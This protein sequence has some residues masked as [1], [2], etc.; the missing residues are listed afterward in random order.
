MYLLNNIEEYELL[1]EIF[2]SAGDIIFLLSTEGDILNINIEAVNSYGYTEEELLS[3]NIFQ[4]INE[5]KADGG[6]EQFK[7]AKDKP[8]IFESKHFRKDGSSFNVEVKSTD[9]R[10]KNEKYVLYII[11]DITERLKIEKENLKWAYKFEKSQESI[12]SKTLDE[13]S[14]ETIST[15]LE[16][17]A[18]AVII[19]DTNGDMEYVNKKFEVLTGYNKEEAIGQ[20]TSILNSHVQANEFYIKMWE[21]IDSGREWRGEFCNRRKDG[22]LFWWSSSISSVKD[23]RGRI[24]KFLAV[25]E[26]TTQKRNF[27]EEITK[28]NIELE[29]ALKS[30][31]ELQV[32][33]IQ[34]DKM[35]SVGQLSAGIAHEIN[36]PLGFVS[37]N[38]NTLKK[39]IDKLSEY[40][41]EYRKLKISMEESCTS[42]VSSVSNEIETINNLE[43]NSKVDY[44]MND[45]VDLYKDTDDGLH[46]IKKIVGT[47]RN[48]ARESSNDIFEDYDLN[49]GIEDT[50][51]ISKSETKYTTLIKVNLSEKIPI[52][53]A[54]PGEIN[55]VLLNL[56]I[57][58]SHA[59][60]EKIESNLCTNGE[61]NIK[62][63]NDLDFVYCLIEDNGNGISK[64]N[65]SKIFNPFFTTKPVGKGTGLGLSISYDIIVNKHKGDIKVES[66][67]GVGTKFIIKLPI[68]SEESD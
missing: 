9:I 40:I 20:N 19:T 54:N 36:N 25:A 13:I 57:N 68:N 43:K 41:L 59:V 38:F 42:C 66:K 44:I 15:A 32:Q 55:Q 60:K 33:L 50:L 11:R 27:I 47:L 5:K 52:I 53:K 46:R 16:N 62:T 12:I 67:L 49:Q 4:I 7:K 48:F 23:E 26:D 63:W 39:Y 18:S 34:E 3:M 1:R 17:S 24:V 58:S 30:L 2:K 22:D 61:L 37:S 8:I 51:V 35:A 10:V 45:L 56:I 31:K 64:D 29:K 28:K 6:R 21:T 14:I 65:I